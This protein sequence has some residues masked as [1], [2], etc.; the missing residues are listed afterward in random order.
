MKKL[1]FTGCG[2]AIAT[3]F[4]NDG[5]NFAEFKR[6]IEF[7]ISNG[8]NALIVCGTT[9]EASTMTK[10]EKEETIKFAIQKVDKRVPV[11]RRTV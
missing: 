8:V 2:T 4:T 5:V 1:L 9:G 6:L 11:I 10:T 7:Q 3:P